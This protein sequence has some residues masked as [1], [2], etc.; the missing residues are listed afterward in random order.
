MHSLCPH[1]GGKLTVSVYAVGHVK[2]ER[3]DW[4]KK[5]TWIARKYDVTYTSV[6]QARARHAPDTISKRALTQQ[7]WSGVDWSQSNPDI[8][9]QRGCYSHNVSV[10]RAKFAP[11]TVRKYRRKK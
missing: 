8:A 5:N 6:Q 7:D 2:W 4:S 3:V 9:K 10:A 11:Q 1:C